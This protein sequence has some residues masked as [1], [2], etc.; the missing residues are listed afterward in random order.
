MKNAVQ[1]ERQEKEFNE[2]IVILDKKEQTILKRIR[3][4]LIKCQKIDWMACERAVCYNTLQK[5]S[6]M[7]DYIYEKKRLLSVDAYKMYR[8]FFV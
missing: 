3:Q 5:Q 1:I 6:K 2:A 7:R 4:Y 8:E